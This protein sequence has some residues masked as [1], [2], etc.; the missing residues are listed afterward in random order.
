MKIYTKKGDTGETGLI[1]GERRSKDDLVFQALGDI[2][3]LNA[4]IGVTLV[5][6]KNAEGE[7]IMKRLQGALFE[8]G[9][10]LASP[11]QSRAA[12]GLTQ[13]T[14]DMEEWIDRHSKFMPELKN[15]ILPG[16]TLMAASLHYARAVCR[17]AERSVVA[18]SRERSVRPEV[19]T[20]MNR[21]SDWL[22]TAARYA[23][24][25]ARVEDT[26]W[27]GGR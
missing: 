23:N 13:M 16:G 26:T 3:E 17:R 5:H 4:A 10:E 27:Q 25:E 6:S 2:D 21:T 14:E 22:F 11:D 7:T 20:L 1:G 12:A 24:H 18:L 9:A 8:L 15:F 19:L